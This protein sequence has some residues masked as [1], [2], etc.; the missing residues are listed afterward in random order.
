MTE[1]TNTICVFRI[2]KVKAETESAGEITTHKTKNGRIA[3]YK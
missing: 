1:T 3:V 2:Y